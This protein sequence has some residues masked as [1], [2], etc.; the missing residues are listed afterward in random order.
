MTKMLGQ[1]GFRMLW[2]LRAERDRALE[3]GT[4]AAIEIS[5]LREE[6][7]AKGEA[8]A[9]MQRRLDAM[10]G[11]VEAALSS[12]EGQQRNTMAFMAERDELQRKLDEA[13]KALGF[14]ASVQ[15]YHATGWQGDMDPSPVSKDNG[16]LARAALSQKGE[17]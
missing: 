13:L 14:Y 2:D 9:L 7:R 3:A 17:G 1:E 10:A 11:Q 12:H 4:D 6:A 5:R 16:F 8:I 15:N